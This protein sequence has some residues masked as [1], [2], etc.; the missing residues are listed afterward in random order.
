MSTILFIGVIFVL[1]LIANAYVAQWSTK[2]VMGIDISLVNSGLVVTGRT[3]A[4]LLAGFAIGYAINIG[5][6]GN[7]DSVEGM[8]KIMAMSIVSIFS[9]LVYW[10]LLGK[11]TKTKISLW[12]MTKTAA[13]ETVVMLS[14]VVVISLILSSLY[15][16]FN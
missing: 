11:F 12:G 14:S 9:F 16:M 2:K 5:L 1:S 10:A 7:A 3:F 13:T 4:S 8:I 6:T 15:F